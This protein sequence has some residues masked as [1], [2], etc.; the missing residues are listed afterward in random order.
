M[1]AND[2]LLGDELALRGGTALH[3]LLLSQQYR[4]SE[5]L[6][7][8][9]MS[10]GG[11]GEVMK[12]LTWLGRELGFRVNTTMAVYPKVIW[13]FV[14]ASGVAGKIKIEINT[15]E[16]LAALPLIRRSFDVVCDGQDIAA[17]VL[18]YQTEEIAATK[19]RALY[20]RSK[21]RDLFD[22]WLVLTQMDVDVQAIVEAFSFY[23][24]EGV[25]ADKLVE[26][27]SK[28]LDDMRFLHDVD[29][30]IRANSVRYD[31][32]EAAHLVSDLL[33]RPLGGTSSLSSEKRTPGL[34]A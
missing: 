17:D 31:P 30:L 9:R 28:K 7:Y 15:Q 5:D 25:T 12:R 3:K 19:I 29:V 24:P 6:D 8:V 1:I 26:N 16:R 18:T 33:L 20:Q 23:R 21:G 22:L 34:G 4:Y 11:I 10:A 14:C 27:L 2:P 13:R 32:I